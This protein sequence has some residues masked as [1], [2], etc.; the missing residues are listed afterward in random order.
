MKELKA[1]RINHF[2]VIDAEELH[3]TVN[4]QEKHLLQFHLWNNGCETK[5]EVSFSL[6]HNDQSI[7]LKYFV[8]EKQFRA[9]VTKMNG[10]VWED[11][12]VEF[13]VA[14]DE[15]GYYNFEFNSIGTVLTAFG[16][17]RD[18]RTFLPIEVLMMIETHTKLRKKN[19]LFYWELLIVIPARV[20]IYHALPHLSGLKCKANFYKCGDALSLPHYL[21]WSNIESESPNFHLPQFFGELCFE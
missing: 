5:P 4:K 18:E 10:R 3:S 6:A 9:I 11:S 1:L 19:N 17:D 2:D 7:F 12:C 20:F 14:F 8:E 13:F 21:T 15:L 16:K